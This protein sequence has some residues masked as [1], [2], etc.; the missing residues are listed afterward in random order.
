[1]DPKKVGVYGKTGAAPLFGVVP[2]GAAVEEALL[3]LAEFEG[4]V[5]RL[6][7]LTAAVVGSMV[8]VKGGYLWCG[9]GVNCAR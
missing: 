4:G 9:M 8:P 6:P 2:L 5:R 3:S 1:V 7:T